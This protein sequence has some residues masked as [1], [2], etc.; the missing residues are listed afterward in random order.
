MVSKGQ[1]TSNGNVFGDD[2]SGISWHREGESEGKGTIEDDAWISGLRN[3]GNSYI[4]YRPEY[5]LGS[6]E[7]IAY[8]ANEVSIPEQFSRIPL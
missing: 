2:L 5:D 6:E 4:I 8:E 3:E 7:K 1:K